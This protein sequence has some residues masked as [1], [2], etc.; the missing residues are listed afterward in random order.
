MHHGVAPLEEV[1]GHLL[2]CFF[3]A[4]TFQ[5]ERDLCV[6]SKLDDL[7]GL[8]LCLELFH[9]DRANIAERL[10]RFFQS[11]FRGVFPAFFGAAPA[12]QLL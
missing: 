4:T 3:H 9:I 7:F 11:V 1:K 12:L 6:N 2:R 5:I 8:N 10:L